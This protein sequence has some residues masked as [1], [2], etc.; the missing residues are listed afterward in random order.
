MHVIILWQFS[1]LKDIDDMPPNIQ[2]FP[3]KQRHLVAYSTAL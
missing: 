2:F 3:I 1:F